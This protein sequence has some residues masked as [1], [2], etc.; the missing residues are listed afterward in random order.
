V[1]KES[2]DNRSQKAGHVGMPTFVGEVFKCGFVRSCG[3]GALTT[4]LRSK[5]ACASS[6]EG[7]KHPD[8]GRETNDDGRIGRRCG[9]VL[10]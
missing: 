5:V 10:L 4:G 1:L 6:G 9:R 8:L 3:E 7:A 2:R